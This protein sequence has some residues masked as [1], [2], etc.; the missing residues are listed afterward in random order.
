[1]NL[2]NSNAQEMYTLHTTH[3]IRRKPNSNPSLSI[4]PS[5]LGFLPLETPMPIM[6]NFSA[7]LF[8]WTQDTEI[9]EYA[10]HWTFLA[11]V[12]DGNV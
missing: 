8:S 5:V 1:M 11:E 9:E 3:F 12:V 4:Q 6:I 2:A 7:H 10:Y